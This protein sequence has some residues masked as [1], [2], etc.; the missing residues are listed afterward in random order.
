MSQPPPQA[1][2][3]Q[4]PAIRSGFAASL[5]QTQVGFSAPT[6]AK[7]PDTPAGSL[8]DA[9][10]RAAPPAAAAPTAAAPTATGPTPPTTVVAT[11]APA[12]ALRPEVG[13]A[14]SSRE[15]FSDA[16]GKLPFGDLID[17]IDTGFERIVQ[18]PGPSS[19]PSTGDLG[20]LRDLF[21]QI[22]ATHMGPVRDFVIE[23]KLG[24]PPREWVEL[25]LPAVSTLR[26]SAAGMGLDDLCVS[27]DAFLAAL[28]VAASLDRPTL[29]DEPRDRLLRAYAQIAGAMPEVFALDDERDRREPIIVQSLLKQVP[30]VRKVALD[31]LYGAGLTSLG[32]YYVAKPYD[33]AEAAGIS[34]DL[35][36]RIVNRFASYKRE[37][38]G[39]APDAARSREYAQLD[40]LSNRL[41][42]QNTAFDV[43]SK[44]WSKGAG[45]DKRRLRRERAETVLRINVL[46][47]RLGE[48][49]LV[50]RLER[51]PFHA[52]VD[53]LDEY[54]QDAK[55]QHA[56]AGG[57]QGN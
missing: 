46:L 23:L 56:H 43:A 12:T 45:K 53:L 37:V 21:N 22:A 31:K 14:T 28:E 24:E 33:V 13:A 7:A 1:P 8:S 26:K 11:G 27:L 42:E 54:L 29:S 32:M 17:D 51:L 41:R 16:K 20:E 2:P 44:G 52:K 57:N 39:L 9:I 5:K 3:A 19:A 36:A 25:V 30:D 10:A 38:A 50:G 34:L 55:A 40:Q 4:R 18:E 47:A 49:D 6:A 35:A 15:P 48:V